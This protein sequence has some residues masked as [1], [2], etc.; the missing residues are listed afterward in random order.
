MTELTICH[1]ISG[2]LTASEYF[3]HLVPYS[4]FSKS[5]ILLQDEGTATVMYTFSYPILIK[6]PW[7]FIVPRTVSGAVMRPWFIC[8]FRR[9]I[10][11]LFACLRN[12]LPPFFLSLFSL[13]F[14]SLL[15]YFLTYLSTPSGIDPFHFQAG[16]RKR[17]PNLALVFMIILCCSIFCYGC[18]F[19]FAVLVFVFQY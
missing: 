7:R 4:S 17:R 14:S 6:R 3:L 9:C 13:L 11:C 19:A 10:N 15:V 8:W 16:G 12:L 2:G 18:V 1:M 5:D